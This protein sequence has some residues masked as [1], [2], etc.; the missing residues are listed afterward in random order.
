MFDDLFTPF[1]GIFEPMPDDGDIVPCDWCS[2]TG[3]Y[4]DGSTCDICWGAKRVVM[5]DGGPPANVATV[6]GPAFRDGEGRYHYGAADPNEQ[7][8]WFGGRG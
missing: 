8:Q 7:H 5:G 4:E 6:F 1:T 2:G 3:K